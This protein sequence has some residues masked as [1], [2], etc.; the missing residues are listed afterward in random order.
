MR[1][2]P[3][4]DPLPLSPLRLP[5][6]VLRA[7]AALAAALICGGTA[8]QAADF[9]VPAAK[10]E[11]AAVQNEDKTPEVDTENIFG[12]TEGSDVNE[13]GERQIS[14]DMLGRFGRAH[15][16]PA[17]AHY[18]GGEGGAEFEYG[19]TDWLS[20]GLGTSFVYHDIRNIEAL[21]DRR[22]GGFNGLSGQA[23]FRLIDRAGAPVGMA[24]SIEPE[25]SRFSDDSGERVDSFA[26]NTRLM[27]DRE[28]VPDRLF[29]ALNV[30]YSPE[31]TH[32]ADGTGRESSLEVSAALAARVAPGVFLGG[33]LRYLSSFEGA[34]FNR[35]D[36]GAFYAGPSFYARLSKAGYVKAA[37][38]YQV[39]GSSPEGAGNLDLVGHDRHQVRLSFGA[40]F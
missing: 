37:Y 6:M 16:G 25:W 13:Q 2:A 3:F 34:A 12:F 38:S 15:A 4:D 18:F 9:G 30:A 7:T 28:L 39:A 20:L 23:K 5:G 32:G 35:F 22:G 8:A 17:A 40:E 29:G 27:I 11:P 21:D 1:R 26:L 24:I 31:W 33:E 14:V 10:A 36:G 19:A